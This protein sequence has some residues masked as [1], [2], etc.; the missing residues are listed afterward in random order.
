MS[1]GALYYP[2]GTKKDPIPFESLYIPWIYKEIY[3][4]GIYTDVLNQK[5][6]SLGNIIVLDAIGVKIPT[7]GS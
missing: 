4:D 2:K 1:L 5:M 6:I 3:M 7:P